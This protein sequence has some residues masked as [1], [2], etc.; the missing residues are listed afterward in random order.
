MKKL[1][2]S[3]PEGDIDLGAVLRDF[4]KFVDA[5]EKSQTKKRPPRKELRTIEVQLEE[6]WKNTE[7]AMLGGIQS[8][9]IPVTAEALLGLCVPFANPDLIRKAFK[10]QN[11]AR[12]VLG[13]RFGEV[14]DLV[15]HRDPFVIVI[16]KGNDVWA[17]VNPIEG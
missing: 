4:E 8:P 5:A 12:V 11:W 15:N 2:V 17:V 14:A 16:R 10:G 7:Q 9:D 6:L 13:D 1:I 3:T